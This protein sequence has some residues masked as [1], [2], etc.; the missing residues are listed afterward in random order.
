MVE[1]WVFMRG[2]WKANKGRKDQLGGSRRAGKVEH[3]SA[4]T[5]CAA[6]YRSRQHGRRTFMAQRGEASYLQRKQIPCHV[7]AIRDFAQVR[8]V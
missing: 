2:K 1:V 3:Q 7:K 5:R 6:G 4:F 8:R